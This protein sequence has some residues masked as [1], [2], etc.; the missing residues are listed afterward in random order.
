M[1][2]GVAVDGEH[3]T[4]EAGDPDRRAGRDR[5]PVG[6]DGAP[7]LGRDPDDAVGVS[8]ALIATPVRPTT[9]SPWAAG[10]R[11]I[12]STLRSTI[13]KNAPTK[14]AVPTSTAATPRCRRGRTGTTRRAAGRSCR[15]CPTGRTGCVQLDDHQHGGDEQD[16]ADQLHRQHAERHDREDQHRADRAREDVAGHAA[17]ARSTRD[18]ARRRRT[19]GSDPATCRNPT[20]PPIERSTTGVPAVSSVTLAVAERDRLTV[21]LVEE[22][23]GG[24]RDEVDDPVGE[25]LFGADADRVGHER[26]GHIGVAVVPPQRSRASRRR[27]RSRPCRS[28]PR[29]RYPPGSRHPRSCRAPSRRCRTTAE[30]TTPPTPPERPTER[31][32]RPRARRRSG[33]PV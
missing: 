18:R 17:R 20:N 28:R 9:V 24:R 26:L 25:C 23:L 16:D 13:A 22:R 11:R 6:R 3:E 27:R 5:G 7:F 30:R 21:D 29:R 8:P 19:R 12:E 32:S 10:M 1:L 14:T 4:V 33:S 2:G 31:R 15:R